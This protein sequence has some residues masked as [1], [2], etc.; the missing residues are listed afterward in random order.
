MGMAL[1]P[2]DTQTTHLVKWS[3]VQSA[4][5][6]VPKIMLM[7]MI[8]LLT[9]KKTGQMRSV[10][11]TFRKEK[12]MVYALDISQK[13]LRAFENEKVANGWGNGFILFST[14]EELSE[15]RNTTIQLLVLTYN[16]HNSKTV[17]KFSDK[18]SGSK[19]VLELA[20]GLKVEGETSSDK[21]VVQKILPVSKKTTGKFSGK[22]IRS[23]VDKNPRRVGTRGYVSHEILSN[24]ERQ[25]ISFEDYKRRGGRTIDLK[26]DISKGWAEVCGEKE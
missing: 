26:W 4:M 8:R 20:K 21:P 18:L 12:I 9:Q 13:K 25:P 19:R 2:T 11:L 7:I 6:L 1:L 3:V 14:A 5:G 22:L 17:N 23:T 16:N 10:S 24:M 15:N